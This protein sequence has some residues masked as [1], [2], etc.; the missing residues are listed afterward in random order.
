VRLGFVVI[1]DADRGGDDD[2]SV[3]C[4]DMRKDFIVEG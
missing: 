3:M 4:V 1:I 2:D